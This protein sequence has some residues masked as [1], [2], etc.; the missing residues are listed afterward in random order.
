[1]CTT[2][3]PEDSRKNLS[4]LRFLVPIHACSAKRQNRRLANFACWKPLPDPKCTN[5]GKAQS[6]DVLCIN[7]SRERTKLRTS[8]YTDWC[9]AKPNLASQILAAQERSNIWWKPFLALA[10]LSR[11]TKGGGIRSSTASRQTMFISQ[12]SAAWRQSGAACTLTRLCTFH[13]FNLF[14]C[15]PLYLCIN[16]YYTSI[17]LYPS[18]HPPTHPPIHPSMCK[19]NTLHT[20]GLK[21]PTSL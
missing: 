16:L 6:G 2:V 4:R 8:H 5:T 14:V 21:E 13:L 19:A 7:T 3:H 20:Y 11:E 15:L 1:M 18:T 9:F 17:M 12:H 10:P